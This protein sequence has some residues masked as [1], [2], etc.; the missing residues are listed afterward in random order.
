VV[1]GDSRGPAVSVAD[2]VADIRF[3]PD[4]TM[5]VWTKEPAHGNGI[6]LVRADGSELRFLANGRTPRWHPRP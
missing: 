1:A 3:S 5:L 6:Y 2:G 4:G